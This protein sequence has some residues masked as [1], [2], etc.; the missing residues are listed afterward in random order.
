MLLDQVFAEFLKELCIP[1][2]NCFL[3]LT[4]LAL[5]LLVFFLESMENMLKFV[6]I[7]KDLN[8]CSQ[9]ATIDIFNKTFTV[10]IVHSFWV[11]QTQDSR[12]N[13]WELLHLHLLQKLICLLVKIK[14]LIL[15]QIGH[16]KSCSPKILP[17]E[18][19]SSR[20][21]YH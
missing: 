17:A 15:S 2:D 8:H 7:C 18:T 13:I 9:E 20:C 14:C 12:Y 4:A 11:F 6:S 16:V 5:D 10:N 21:V 3:F 19:R 1:L